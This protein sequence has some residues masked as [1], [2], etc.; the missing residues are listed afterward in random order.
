MAGDVSMSNPGPPDDGPYVPRWC[1]PKSAPKMCPCG[2]HEGY[3]ND[4][5]RC[6]RDAE[7]RCAGLPADCET[8]DEEFFS[9]APESGS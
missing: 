8:S 3:H 6:L 9:D 5:R 7:C 2:H 4:D 1:Y